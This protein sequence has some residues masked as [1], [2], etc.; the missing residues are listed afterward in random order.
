VEEIGKSLPAVFKRHVRRN[1][2]QLV[3]ILAAMW[4][5]IAGKAVA[6]HSWPVAIWS[7]TLTIA[8]PCS[9]W[10]AQLQQLEDEIRAAANAFLGGEAVRELRVRLAP[11]ETAPR[12]ET[13]KAS[14]E[15]AQVAE[16]SVS[17]FD[18]Q[19][20]LDPEIARI[21]EHSYSKYFSRGVKRV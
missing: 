19:D 3:E 8:T 16:N 4:G 12:S 7:G 21:L 11:S 14:P 5:R 17:H 15:T 18:D 1:D 13:R 10:L 6:E 20:G 9:T 2:P